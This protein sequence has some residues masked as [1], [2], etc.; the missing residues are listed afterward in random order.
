M[1]YNLVR[2][3]AQVELILDVAGPDPRRVV[4]LDYVPTDDDDPLARALLDKAA[5][6]VR[7]AAL[8]EAAAG[9]PL[10][11]GGIS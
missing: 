11:I 6:L 4:T 9:R 7:A 8:A 2:V 3:R 10:D 5:E 1:A